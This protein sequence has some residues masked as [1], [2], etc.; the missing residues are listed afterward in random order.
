MNKFLKSKT[1]KAALGLVAVF[2][3]VGVYSASAY[4]FTTVL[5]MG[6][7]GEAVRE[8]QKALNACSDTMVASTGA[9][10]P[11]YETSTFAGKTKAAVMKLQA[12]AGLSQVGQVGPLTR[13][14][15]NANGCGT[16]STGNTGNTGGTVVSGQITASVAS[17]SPANM[18]LA[19]G[20]AFN[21]VLKLRLANGTSSPVNVTGLNLTKTGFMAN[22]NVGGVSVYDSAGMQHGNTITSLGAN[23]IAMM[24]FPTSPITVPA[25]GTTDILVKVN[26][27]SSA[28]SGTIGMSV[29]SSSDIMLSSGTAG[30]TFPIAGTQMT[31]VSGT[32]SLATITLGAQVSACGT[33]G[34]TLNVDSA[35]SQEISKFRVAETSSNEDVKLYS[36]ALWNNGNA[37]ASDYRDVQ[38]LDQTGN[39]VATAQPSG[40][41]VKF[42]LA[43]PFLVGKGQTKDFTVRAT[44]NGGTT[45]TIQFTVYNDYDLDIRGVST[46]VSV[47]P[48][49][50]GDAAGDTGFPVGDYTSTYNKATVGSGSL[51]FNRATDSASTSV[52]PSTEVSLAKFNAKPTGQDMEVRGISFGITQNAANRLTGTVFVK[53]NGQIVYNA[54]GT[55]ANFATAGGN[56]VTRSLSSYPVL[57]AG[58]NNTIEVV[59]SIDSSATS[60]STFKVEDFDVTSVKRLISNDIVDPEVT[61][62]DG[63]TLTAQAA[64]LSV[65]TLTTPVAAS[66]VAGTNG[67]ELANISLNA[68][69]SGEDVRISSIVI[70]DTKDSSASYI[71]ITNLVMK[72]AS[73]NQLTTSASTNTDA[74]TVTF[75]FT[76][77]IILAKNTSTV[78]KLYGD[79]VTGTSTTRHLFDVDSVTATGKYTGNSISVTP[80]GSGQYMTITTSGTL[81]ISTVSGASATPT[82][83]QTVNMNTLDNVYLA[84]KWTSQYEAQ[85]VTTLKLKATGTA[86]TTNNIKNIRLYAKKGSYTSFQSDATLFASVDQFSTCSSNVCSFTWTDGSNVLPFTIDPGMGVT[87]WVKADIQGENVVKLGNDFYMSVTN[88]GT[89][90][91]AQGAVSGQAPGTYTG[92]ANS[93]GTKT[94]ITPFQVLVTGET[95]TSGGSSSSPLSVGTQIGRFKVYN[96]GSAQIT[97]TDATF[98][99][100]GSHTGTST[101][102]TVYASSEGTNDYTT[103]LLEVSSTD[104]VAFGS[105]GTS[106]T[107]NGGS[108]RYVTVA[109]TTVGSIAT[110]DNYSL[111]V[112]SMGD[113]KYSVT[114]TA[115]GYDGEQDGDITGTITGLYTNGLPTLGNLYK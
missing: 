58:Q 65:T 38:L 3:L 69:S 102:Y 106:I 56:T 87:V 54:A 26:L 96:G 83:T 8:L 109:I 113:V 20:S 11:G 100:S 19:G 48:T 107:I 62:Q 13:A 68:G 50:G 93:S 10:S 57:T 51:A 53:V 110:N 114:E 91:I 27:T 16:G 40:N 94:Y 99:N 88:D 43:T 45:R 76:N 9:G 23:G 105:L 30:G 1:V 34:C 81:T 41:V 64:N 103:N 17:D 14:F 63:L 55:V 44:I 82:V 84:Y 108:F 111:S 25:N 59:A 86:L 89:D 22:T 46:G 78:L 92:T 98:T 52:A 101:R 61:A 28:T 29:V 2:A 104:S 4:N 85:K 18:T 66:V 115:L 74:A 24:S 72:D 95:P 36:L 33:S 5:K 71:D 21:P 79:V 60:S 42:N 37:S 32:S 90:V 67:F 70:A 49:V 97:L 112:A 31:V 75:T 35:S 47:L 12:K 77:P 73:G 7:K 6:S 15:L 80:S 39:V